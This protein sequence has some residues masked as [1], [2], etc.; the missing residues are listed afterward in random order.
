MMSPTIF[1]QESAED[2]LRA[3]ITLLPGEESFKGI[4]TDEGFPKEVMI[5]DS[6]AEAVLTALGSGV[7]KKLVFKGYEAVVYAEKDVDLGSDP[8]NAFIEGNFAKRVQMYFLRNVGGGRLRGHFRDGLKQVLG[9]KEWDP[10]LVRD[11][12]TFLGF[13]EDD[14]VKK[15]QSIELIWLPDR[16]LC[17]IVGGESYPPIPSSD[18]ASALWA[19]WLGDKP[20]SKD[21]KRDMLRFVLGSL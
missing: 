19:I 11:F 1:A 16:G 14:G 21:L 12:E 17:T 18:L 4:G 13:F 10:I 6:G 3:A 7:R 9:E 5:R 8:Y 2:T 15:R 20:V